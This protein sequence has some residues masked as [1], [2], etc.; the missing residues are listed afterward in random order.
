MVAHLY[1]QQLGKFGVSIS[2]QKSL[3]STTGAGEFAKRFRV[4]GMSVDLSPISIRSLNNFYNP[5]G[6]MAL[7]Q[8]YSIR[9]F[10]TAC[11]VG[12]AGYRTVSRLSSCR[13]R[14]WERFFWMYMKAQYHSLE[15]WLGRG[16]P[17]NPYWKGLMVDYLRSAMKPTDIRLVPEDKHLSPHAC[18]LM[19]YTLQRN[20]VS[21]WLT[22]VKWY[23]SVA[24]SP[25]EVVGY[26]GPEGR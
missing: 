23:C 1:E 25:L 3:I 9:R 5:Y 16:L 24:L 12:G 20:W 8:K 4:K 7:C 18:E 17:L 2:V 10:S 6:L 21:S 15:W 14:K 13:S 22:Y 11:R 26:V 19:E